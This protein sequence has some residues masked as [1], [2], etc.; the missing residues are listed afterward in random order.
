MILKTL[1][2][3]VFILT[4]LAAICVYDFENIK[5]R[6]IRI[7]SLFEFVFSLLDCSF[8]HTRLNALGNFSTDL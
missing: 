6:R 3:V 7:V 1:N 4:K 5:R 2:D 8:D